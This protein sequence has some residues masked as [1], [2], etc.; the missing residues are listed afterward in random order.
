MVT[1]CG[2]IIG[3]QRFAVAFYT[4]LYHVLHGAIQGFQ[5]LRSQFHTEAGRLWQ[6][7]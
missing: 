4:I 7:S 1:K 6:L 5:T 2:W 3:C